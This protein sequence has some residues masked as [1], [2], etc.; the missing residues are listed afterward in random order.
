MKLTE[1]KAFLAIAIV[2]L[3]LTN[4]EA[5]KLNKTASENASRGNVDGV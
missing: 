1:L 3:P 2:S 5:K 4:A